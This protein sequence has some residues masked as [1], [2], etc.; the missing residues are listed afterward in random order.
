MKTVKE[1]LELIDKASSVEVVVT[2]AKNIAFCF[3]VT[4]EAAKET[5]KFLDLHEM[6]HC[7]TSPAGYLTLGD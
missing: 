7:V 4:K 3:P 2:L 1:A 5:L 6:I